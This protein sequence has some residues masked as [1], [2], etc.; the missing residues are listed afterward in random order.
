MPPLHKIYSTFR[1][2]VIVTDIYSPGVQDNIN[3]TG[4]GLRWSVYIFYMRRHRAASCVYLPPD[5]LETDRVS[6]VLTTVF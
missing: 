6:D 5:S 1:V 2:T 4:T 3:T